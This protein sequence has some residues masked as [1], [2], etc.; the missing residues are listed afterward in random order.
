MA[1]HRRNES[2]S[3]ESRTITK[4]PGGTVSDRVPAEAFPP[5]EYL[6]DE[7]EERGWTQE[8]FASIIGRSPAVINQIISGKRGISPET[9]REIGAALGTSAMYWMNLESAYRLWKAGPAPARIS[10]TGRLRT[11]F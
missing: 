3:S 6:K 1:K 11:K 8:E 9:A 5:G 7:M 2:E 10:H 4:H